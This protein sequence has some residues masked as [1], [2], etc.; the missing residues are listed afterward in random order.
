MNIAITRFMGTLVYFLGKSIIRPGC[1]YPPI[2]KD[3]IS[4]LDDFGLDQMISKPIR[5]DNV[6]DLFLT[7]NQILISK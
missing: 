6:L 7:F 3:F 2:N 1:S 5:G 4:C